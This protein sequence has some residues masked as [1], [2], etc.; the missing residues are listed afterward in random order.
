MG[1]KETQVLIDRKQLRRKLE[2][3]EQLAVKVKI[4]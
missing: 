2:N 3:T 4:T 1:I